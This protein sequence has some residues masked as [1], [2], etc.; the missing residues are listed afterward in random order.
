MLWKCSLLTKDITALKT[1]PANFQKFVIDRNCCHYPAWTAV[2]CRLTERCYNDTEVPANDRHKHAVTRIRIL[3]RQGF[4]N[5]AKDNGHLF[6]G[7]SLPAS[8]DGQAL[9]CSGCWLTE[10]WKSSGLQDMT[11]MRNQTKKNK[12]RKWHVSRQHANKNK[13]VSVQVCIQSL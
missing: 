11:S 9:T 6:F 7:W 4:T 10:R 5:V 13:K 2:D 12:T 8:E 3:P 1:H